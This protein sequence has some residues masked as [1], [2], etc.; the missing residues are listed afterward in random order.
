MSELRV[1][2]MA[3]ALR[4]PEN[5]TADHK[6]EEEKKSSRKTTAKREF[7]ILAIPAASDDR[8]AK[9]LTRIRMAAVSAQSG[10]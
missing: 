1:L 4:C 7:E 8:F 6:T 10:I 2:P 9:S 5:K 3:A